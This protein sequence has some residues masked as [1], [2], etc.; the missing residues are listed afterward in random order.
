MP[1]T[2][3]VWGKSIGIV[4]LGRIGRAVARRRGGFRHAASPTAAARRRT[5][6]PIP[7]A[8]ISA[9]LAR[10]VEYPGLLRRGRRRHQGAD[11][12]ARPS[13]RCG[14][15]AS[16]STSRAARWC[17]EAALLDALR[18]GRIGVAGLDVFWNEPAI[19]PR[20]RRARQC[21]A[22]A[23]S[24][25]GH[26][27]D[28]QGD[29]P[30]GAR[31]P[32]RAFR[33]PAPAHPGGL[34]RCPC[35]PSSS[36][37]P[38]DL[39][40]EEQRARGRRPRRGRGRASR[41]AASAAPTC[42]TTTHGGFGTVRLREPMI[43][44]HEV[45]GTVDAVGEGVDAPRARRPRRGQSRAGPAAPAATAWRASRTTASTCASTAAR[46]ASRMSRAPSARRWSARRRS[47]VRSPDGM[48]DRARPPSPSRFAVCLHAVEPR[49]AAARQAR[50][51]H[52]LRAD[53]RAG[54][55]AAR[56][57]ARA[58][59]SRPTSPTRRS[60]TARRIGADRTDQRR[61]RPGR[62]RAPTAPTRALRRDVRGLAATPR[63][64]RPALD[65]LR[66]R[67]V[68]VQL[69]LGGDVTPA[70]EPGRRQGDRDARH[71]P[72]PR[73]IR[74]GGRTASA[75]ARSTRCRC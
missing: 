17:D 38:K 71:L 70:A 6:C 49:R 2:T 52:R 19:D 74:A 68:L 4:G 15:A 23:A 42:T 27:R 51:G 31:Q 14:P 11:R 48:Y 56:A 16:S 37:P 65:V 25:R 13:R 40:V 64:S 46:C 35:A 72:L 67:G 69:G 47:A 24:R 44:G 66:P 45:A 1:L 60:P 54:I 62:A 20:F 7:S 9:A 53:R 59:S 10:T 41:P 12:R 8:P 63:R 5:T 58:R 57:P 39:R 29:G 34:R 75:A 3:R 26:R 55:I 30:A 33:R 36:M 73:G 21:R 18:S 22:A 61:R 50:A 28:P 43:L 32:R